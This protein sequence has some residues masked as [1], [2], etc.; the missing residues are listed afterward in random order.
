MKQLHRQKVP[1][2]FLKLD[3]SKAF[4]SVSWSFLLEILSHL[5]FGPS[6]CNLISNLLK[7]ASTRIL[8]NGEPGEPI[9]HQRGLRQGDPLS[10]MLFLLVMDALNSLFLKASET[11]L[12]QPLAHRHASQRISLYADDVVLFIQPT[13]PE[14]SLTMAILAK[15]GEASGLHTNLQKSCVIPISCEQ[16]Q[17][18]E[19]ATTLPC[20]QASFPCIYLGLPI[21]NKKLRKAD[22]LAWVEKVGDR[23]PK[24]KVVLM[25]MAG[26]VAW[27]RF[28]LSAVPIH[29][30]I[31]IKVPK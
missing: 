14:M 3:I 16:N 28:V 23:L 10:P 25:N 26:R 13:V 4:D 30:L 8:V 7:T 2:L 12:L 19:M 31:A 17:V 11:G 24:W 29:V 18:E 27:T 21:S 1:S 20:T 5:G 9:R 15:F 6:W 22:L